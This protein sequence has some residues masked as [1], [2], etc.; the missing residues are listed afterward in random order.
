VAAQLFAHQD[1]PLRSA[2]EEI[3]VPVHI[4]KDDWKN[5]TV[6]WSTYK[7]VVAI[8]LNA[9]KIIESLAQEP[10]AD[11]PVFWIISESITV[12][13]DIEWDAS[14]ELWAVYHSWLETFKRSTVIVFPNY[15]LPLQYKDFYIE[16]FYVL[17][18]SPREVWEA[19]Q[20]MLTHAR[21]D[22]LKK[23]GVSSDDF[24]IVVVGSPCS[25]RKDSREHAVVLKAVANFLSHSSKLAGSVGH[26]RVLFL[27][28][29]NSTHEK[30]A[31]QAS[32]LPISL[33]SFY[34]SSFI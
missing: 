30:H 32:S 11:V 27:A 9:K 20:Y 23:F 33:C 24:V 26:L 2:W 31:I 18:G 12:D 22:V 8:S 21:E 15:F 7:G 34:V 25:S 4:V 6:D 17:P 19:E 5:I 29:E 10:F 3:G 16:N 14:H 28:H 13:Q 1:V